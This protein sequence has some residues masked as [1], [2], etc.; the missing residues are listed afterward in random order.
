MRAKSRSPVSQLRTPAVANAEAGAA[1]LTRPKGDR[2][3]G[4]RGWVALVNNVDWVT[5]FIRFHRLRHPR[6]LE[7]RHLWAFVRHITS[8]ESRSKAHQAAQAIRFLY[9]EVLK[10]T[11]PDTARPPLGNDSPRRHQNRR[12]R[13]DF[14]ATDTT[15]RMCRTPIGV[16]ASACGC[17]LGSSKNTLKRE[18]QRAV[19][20]GVGSAE[21]QPRSFVPARHSVMRHRPGVQSKASRSGTLVYRGLVVGRSRCG[22]MERTCVTAVSRRFVVS[23]P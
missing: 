22:A 1:V 3:L 16:H 2:S 14:G 23:V 4:G 17:T 9:R 18:L 12:R 19:R 10:H 20:L 5:C 13:A 15:R 8:S 7:V 11:P 21:G 6:D